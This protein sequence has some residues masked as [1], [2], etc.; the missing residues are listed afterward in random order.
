MLKS[1]LGASMP[2]PNRTESLSNKYSPTVKLPA[3][4]S[5]KV[6]TFLRLLLTTA[7]PN[8]VSA[9]TLALLIL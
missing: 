5:C 4:F 8:S 2:I 7:G 9:S 6:P 1:P 3:T